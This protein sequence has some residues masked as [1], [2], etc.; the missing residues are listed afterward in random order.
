MQRVEPADV[1]IVIPC[2]EQKRFLEQA[3]ASAVAQRVPPREIIVVDDGSSENL[4][5]VTSM[6][7]GVELIRQANRGLA[8]ARNSGL[9]AARGAKII[10]LDADD[11][12][13]PR[14]IEAGCDCFLKNCEAAF[15]YGAFRSVRGNSRERAFS[16]VSTHNDLVRCNWIGMIATVMFDREKVLKLGGFDETLEMVED[17]DLYLRLS[18]CFPFAWHRKTVADYMKH[19]GNASNDVAELKKWIEVVRT[20]EWDRGLDDGGRL[21]WK[22]GEDIWRSNF[23]SNT[24]APSLAARVV[25]RAARL[26]RFGVRS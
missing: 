19:A 5:D 3:I 20:K 16:A 9:K 26:L 1:S 10:F 2:F 15:V 11:R 21:A 13:L 4:S 24:M 6:F 17:W 12:L 23:E 14:A 22:E 25:R 8:G 7:D 18:R